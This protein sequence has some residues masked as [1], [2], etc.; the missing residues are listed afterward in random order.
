M[1]RPI[2]S[3]G[4][5]EIFGEGAVPVG[6]GVGPSEVVGLSEGVGLAAGV[7]LGVVPKMFVSTM[8]YEMVVDSGWAW[9][10][11]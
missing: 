11:V 7:G 9:G 4:T 5:S 1:I 3:I 10:V 8:L 6:E 2:T